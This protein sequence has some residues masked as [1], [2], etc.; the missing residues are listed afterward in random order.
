MAVLKH[1]NVLICDMGGQVT[2]AKDAFTEII[3]LPD[4]YVSFKML[5]R[6]KWKYGIPIH[7]FYHPEML[8]DDESHGKQAGKE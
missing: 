2:L 8:A 4:T 7:Y 5:Q 6:L 3:L 1:F